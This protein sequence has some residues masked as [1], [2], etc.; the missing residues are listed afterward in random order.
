MSQDI[1]LG[2]DLGGTKMLS[3]VLDH[4]FNILNRQKKATDGSKKEIKLFEDMVQLMQHALDESGVDRKNL[5]GIGVGSPGPLDPFAG[6]ILNTPNLGFKNFPMK[7]KLEDIFG[8]PVSIDNDV[9]AGIY[10]EFKF[11]A[12]RGFKH[13]VGISPGTGVGGCV[14]LDSQLFRGSNGTAGELGHW[15]IRTDSGNL[16]DLPY[17]TVEHL[18]SRTS[19]A[20]DLAHMAASGRAPTIFEGAG[21]DLKK[22][23]S[24]LIAQ[25]IANGEK[26]VID[27]VRRS[28]QN[29]GV[30]LANIV[31]AYDPECIIFGGGLVPKIGKLYLEEAVQSMIKHAPCDAA[32]KVKVKIGE[33][34][35]D[36]A[37]K[38]SV[39]LLRDGRKA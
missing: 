11:G 12:G 32:R 19:I 36:A 33:L 5:K 14:I 2:F 1:Y 29:M 7:Q 39:A 22:I 9:N 38:G 4:D 18:C 8:V 20:K 35:D 6:V 25:S 13:V 3:A 34:G 28:A 24:S 31:K 10:G 21:T 23:K 30:A 15:V 17:G 27:V 26:V 16:G 37:L